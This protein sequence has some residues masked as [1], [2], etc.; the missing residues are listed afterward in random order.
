[1][2]SVYVEQG[3]L[4]E[5]EAE[6]KKVLRTLQLCGFPSSDADVFACTFG[7]VD[8]YRNTGRADVC[9]VCVWTVCPFFSIVPVRT[10]FRCPPL[11][12]AVRLPA[13]ALFPIHL[14]AST[15]ALLLRAVFCF[16]SAHDS[17]ALN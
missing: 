7:L 2:H 17:I 3:R 16:S 6:Y 11:L 5:G 13:G 9:S 15:L 1:M 8:I 14:V 4:D 10:F 12:A